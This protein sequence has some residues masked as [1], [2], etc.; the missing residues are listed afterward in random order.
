MGA[1]ARRCVLAIVLLVMQNALTLLLRRPY[2]ASLAWRLQALSRLEYVSLAYIVINEN[3]NDHWMAHHRQ[4]RTLLVALCVLRV[5]GPHIRNILKERRESG[6]ITPRR[7]VLEL[8]THLLRTLQVSSTER[9]GGRFPPR[10]SPLSTK[11]SKSSVTST[12]AS[13]AWAAAVS[14]RVSPP[15][16]TSSRR[17]IPPRILS[18]R[19]ASFA[20]RSISTRRRPES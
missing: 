19:I 15:Q 8:G 9:A 20:A 14:R 13:S 11:R 4:L 16:S 5:V 7:R 1:I 6:D 18:P 2:Q 10:P 17:W 12:A 3:A